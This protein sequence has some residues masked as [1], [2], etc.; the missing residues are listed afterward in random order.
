MQASQ[1]DLRWPDRSDGVRR[2]ADSSARGTN[3]IRQI[4]NADLEPHKKEK[5]MKIT[6]CNQ[7]VVRMLRNEIQK[8]LNKVA[9]THG[10]SVRLGSGSYTEQN[11]RF[12]LEVATI[13]QDGEVNNREASDFK[14]MAHL[15]GLKPNDLGKTVELRGTKFEI[16]GL[17]TKS[18]RFPIMG[19]RLYDGKIFKLPAESIASALRTA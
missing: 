8:A 2:Q 5:E 19:K 12:A 3:S 10:V 6:R 13:G 11:V 17:R 4:G 18:Y 1:F 7:D 14:S 16:V 15:Y 9:S